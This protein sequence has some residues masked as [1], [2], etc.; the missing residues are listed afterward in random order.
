MFRYTIKAI[1]LL[2]LSLTTCRVL[3]N[4]ET[5]QSIQLY[6]IWLGIEIKQCRMNIET[7]L[8]HWNK[9]TQT[10]GTRN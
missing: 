7:I 4:I 8:L 1:V 6:T 10:P 2:Y 3:S 5:L 9:S